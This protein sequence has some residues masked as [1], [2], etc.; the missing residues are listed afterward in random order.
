MTDII[1]RQANV[2]CVH[3]IVTNIARRKAKDIVEVLTKF[4]DTEL[5]QLHMAMD[6]MDAVKFFDLINNAVNLARSKRGDA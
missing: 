1:Y 3:D 2:R 6:S 4:S 5:Y